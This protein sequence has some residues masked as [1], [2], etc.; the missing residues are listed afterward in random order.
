M[1][2]PNGASH[3][4]IPPGNAHKRLAHEFPGR[5]A[6][7]KRR[8][9][10]ARAVAQRQL[11]SEVTTNVMLATCSLYVAVNPRSPGGGTGGGEDAERRRSRDEEDEERRRKRPRV[12]V[13]ASRL[14][15]ALRSCAGDLRNLWGEPNG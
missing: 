5:S 3:R 10:S 9:G 12:E 1:G 7:I 13:P 6:I 15:S 4:G 2:G 8:R 14:G 11:W